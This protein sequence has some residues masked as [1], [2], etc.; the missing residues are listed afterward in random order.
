[1]L[2]CKV[3]GFGVDECL[4][5]RLLLT[6]KLVLQ[7]EDVFLLAKLL[8][9]KLAQLTRTSHSCLQTLNAQ[10][11]TVLARLLAQLLRSLTVLSALRC[12]LGCLAGCKLA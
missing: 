2:G 4:L 9:T 12:L 8:A 7:T 5:L 11:R 1:M 6:T 10:T 3:L